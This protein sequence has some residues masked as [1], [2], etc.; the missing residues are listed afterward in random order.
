M[1][2]NA[3]S[4]QKSSEM[5]EHKLNRYRV[6]PFPE[7]VAISTWLQNVTHYQLTKSNCGV[8]ICVDSYCG[9]LRLRL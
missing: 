3:A 8:E 7:M 4:L 5:V 9:P 1:L 2:L 6:Q